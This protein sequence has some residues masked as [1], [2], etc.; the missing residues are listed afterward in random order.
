[1]RGRDAATVVRLSAFAQSTGYLLSIPGPIV[2][3][4]LYEHNGNW[5]IPLALMAALMVP[6]M[7][8][9]FIA[10]RDRQI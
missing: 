5:Q 9:G 4:A 2:V 1:M 8:A 3:G 10:G 7:A 6:Q